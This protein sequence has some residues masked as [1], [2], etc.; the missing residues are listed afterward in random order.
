MKNIKQKIRK[1]LSESVNIDYKEESI[2]NQWIKNNINL[3]KISDKK[4]ADLIVHGLLKADFMTKADK[5]KLQYIFID[6]LQN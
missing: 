4:T 2:R 1:A 3:E 5:V 6:M